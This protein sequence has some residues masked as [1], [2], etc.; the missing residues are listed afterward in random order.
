MQGCFKK[1]TVVWTVGIFLT[2][3]LKSEGRSAEASFRVLSLLLLCCRS[4]ERTWLL[5]YARADHI[6]L[7]WCILG[8]EYEVCSC[9]HHSWVRCDLSME[10]CGELC[11]RTA[12]SVFPTEKINKCVHVSRVFTCGAPARERGGRLRGWLAEMRAGET[13]AW[14]FKTPSLISACT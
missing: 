9:P 3:D 14:L 13:L 4:T 8:V 10:Y 6:W 5:N 2:T 11:V 7:C 1:N 12:W